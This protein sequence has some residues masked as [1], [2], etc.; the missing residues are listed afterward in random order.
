MSV[1]YPAKGAQKLKVIRTVEGQVSGCLECSVFLDF[2]AQKQ[3]VLEETLVGVPVGYVL[4]PQDGIFFADEVQRAMRL[5]IAQWLSQ[6]LSLDRVSG[7]KLSSDGVN[8]HVSF[9]LSA[10][11]GND[12]ELHVCVDAATALDLVERAALQWV[13]GWIALQ[14]R[15]PLDAELV[16]ILAQINLLDAPH[17]RS[18]LA[19]TNPD[20]C[21]T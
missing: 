5:G 7:R 16:E 15:R 20:V 11:D 19:L 3:L 12:C 2:G 4:N 10:C 17:L 13:E 18:G 21:T 14:L 6:E 8:W 9:R 1:P